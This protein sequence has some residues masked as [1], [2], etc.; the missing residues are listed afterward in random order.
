LRFAKGLLER[1][2]WLAREIKVP[3]QLV[4]D[5]FAKRWQWPN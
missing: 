5:W 3:P 2:A 4:S 1:S